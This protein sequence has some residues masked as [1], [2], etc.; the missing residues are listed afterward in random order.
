MSSTV[1][2]GRALLG[3][4]QVLMGPF[5]TGTLTVR[6]TGATGTVPKHSHG[7]PLD[8]GELFDD[9]LLVVQPNPATPDGSWA[10]TS[11]GTPVTVAAV[12]GGTKGNL[13][14]ATQVRW[15]P[16]LAGI[17]AVS[18][19]AGALAGG[20]YFTSQPG[21]PTLRQARLYKEV[22]RDV[23]DALFAG[24]MG[25]DTPAAVLA[26]ESAGPA[27]GTGI[28]AMGSTPSRVGSGKRLWKNNWVLFLVTSR[29]EGQ[30]P[31]RRESDDFRDLA[32]ELL[33]DRTAWRGIPISSPQGLQI[34]E[35][36]VFRVLPTVYVDS[37][38]FASTITLERRDERTFN[39]WTKTRIRVE[40]P[41]QPPGQP[42]YVPN[43]TDPMP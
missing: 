18:V 42:L 7:I 25:E 16:P 32:L 12:L 5:A 1:G 36:S 43:V 35:A 38:R 8:G 31:R 24:Q 34:V 11:A 4:L 41:E 20:S 37:I 3:L 19:T 22:P 9:A 40:Q 30:G 15:D 23:L 27:D 17:K 2:Q 21:T 6:S 29:L 10:V 39:D 33:T 13:A 26:W 28:A 14:S